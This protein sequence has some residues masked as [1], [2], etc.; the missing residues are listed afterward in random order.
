[1][2]L[3]EVNFSEVLSDKQVLDSIMSD[4]GNL[5]KNWIA[6]QWNW[7]NYVY[8]PFK[9]H[10]KYL[11]IISLV[12]KTLQ[13]YDQ[14]NIK[15]SYDEYYSRSF[16]QTEKFSIANLC[17]KLGLPKETVRRKVLELENLGVLV[18]KEKKIIVDRS[19]F[20]LVKPENQIKFTSRY[21]SLVSEILNKKKVYSKKLDSGYIESIIKKNFTMC[22]Y[23]YY[24]MQIPMIFGYVKCFKD[25]PSFHIWGTVVMN[26]T[27]N[28]SKISDEKNIRTKAP[29]YVTYNKNFFTPEKKN[30]G[31]SAMS[32]SDMTGIP[33]AT[34]IRKCKYLMKNDF[35][36]L[37]DNKQYILTGYNKAEV[38]PFQ[39][40][41]FKL[42]AKY[43]R[44][45][46]NLCIVS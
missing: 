11:I 40:E 15:H 41:V 42:K 39:K 20:N 43:I 29:D 30:N 9:D 45:V 12:E 23:W 2:T 37:N 34:V 24:K 44:K 26:E 35:L 28:Y 31:V 8:S 22:W 46:L 27:F 38:I 32:I 7:M 16:I 36:D 33:R 21:I 19:A 13:F 14:V 25:M 17:Q 4:Y 6:H 10:Y 5:V 3:K 1:M 18:R